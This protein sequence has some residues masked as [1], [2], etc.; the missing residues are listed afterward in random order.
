MVSYSTQTA[1][2]RTEVLSAFMR[3]VYGWMSAGL[4]VTG[5]LARTETGFARPDPLPEKYVLDTW[6]FVVEPLAGQASR[7]IL[8]GRQTYAP[9]T[10]AN[11][12]I[13]RVITEP[14]GFVMMRQM[15]IGIK[16]RAEATRR[17]G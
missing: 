17:P 7:L 16:R 9:D 4:L 11:R 2:A 8:R 1:R 3:G 6:C 14:M 15:L 13:W 12:L 10:F 5:D